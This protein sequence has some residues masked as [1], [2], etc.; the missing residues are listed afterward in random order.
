[1]GDESRTPTGLARR[2]R[3]LTDEQTRARMLAAATEMIS[4]T[5]LTVGMDHI[6]FEEVIRAAGVS[7]SSAYRHWPYKDLFFSD[8]VRQL[9]QASSPAILR[10]EV[11]LIRRVI[12]EHLAWL[13]SAK[14]RQHLVLELIRE[15][16]ALDLRSM[17]ASPGWRTYLALHATFTG[18]ADGDLREQIRDALAQSEAARTAQVATAWRQ[19]AT[20]LGYRLRPEAPGG[21]DTLATLLAAT[22]RGLVIT[23]LSTPD[24]SSQQ[25]MAR[26]FGAADDQPWSLPA[27]AAASIAMAFLEPDPEAEWD[28][29]RVAAIHRA[30]DEWTAPAA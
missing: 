5:G 29:E 2:H 6:S 11:G 28:D 16:A 7:R 17:L 25:P 12:G 26:P 13:G 1:M 27:I 21:F 19:F 30:L 15:L 20:L 3:R 4:T 8:L 23:A 22:L 9:A 24:I 14:T 10:D 18:L